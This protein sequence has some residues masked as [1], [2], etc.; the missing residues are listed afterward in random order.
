MPLALQQL[1]LNT[2]GTQWGGGVPPAAGDAIPNLD[3]ANCDGEIW[4][5]TATLASRSGSPRGPRNLGS[6]SPHRRA[7]SR[8][9]APLPC[10]RLPQERL[11]RA[12]ALESLLRPEHKV[13]QIKAAV[14]R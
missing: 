9:V 7:Q 11:L 2:P 13:S 14:K 12:R 3:V 8:N 4:P 6:P 1:L 10:E 5:D